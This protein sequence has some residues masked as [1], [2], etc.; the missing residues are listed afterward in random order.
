MGQLETFLHTLGSN[1]TLFGYDMTLF[2]SIFKFQEPPVML[3]VVLINFGVK[4]QV[5][6]ASFKIVGDLK[7]VFSYEFD[8]IIFYAYLY[9]LE[10]ILD[11]RSDQFTLFDL[12]LPANSYMIA[13]TN[14][15]NFVE[16]GENCASTN[17][18]GT[19]GTFVSHS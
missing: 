5:P 6:Q 1:M 2:G 12:E 14:T 19:L 10:I 16:E 18:S 8:D 3:V 7:L 11:C 15:R 9:F 17:P 4:N 13:C